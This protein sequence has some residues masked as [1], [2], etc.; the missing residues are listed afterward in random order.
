M[1]AALMHKLE[2]FLRRQRIALGD[3]VVAVSG[4]PDSVALLRALVTLKA[5]G[6]DSGRLTVAH[7]NH[8]LRGDESDEDE[9]FVR[10]LT[11]SLAS[12]GHTGLSLHCQRCEVRSQAAKEANNL[13]ATA[14]SLR[15]DWLGETARAARA[16]FVM[17]GHTADDQAETIL[18]HLLRGTGLKGLRGIAARRG[19]V[20]GVELVRPLLNVA[21][22]EV[23]AYLQ[24]VGQDYREDS[25]NA[26]CAF[27]R[28]RIR[29]ELIPY[30]ATNYNPEI[31]SVLTR[32]AEQA[33]ETYQD[34]EERA[35]GLLTSAELP[36]A[37]TC[38]VFSSQRLAAAGRFLQREM[39]RLAWEREGWP[40]GKMGFEDWDRL[41]Q[42][43]TGEI[44]ALDFPGGI[45]ARRR[46]HVVLIGPDS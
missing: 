15:Y 16:H 46:D 39:F 13:E 9:R 38:L 45:R 28:N 2:G 26:N 37:G 41:T 27:T 10:L 19:L 7:F 24:E 32:L 23:L 5:Q 17:T 44:V 22:A 25:S 21:R 31:V 18:H 42:V 33:A 30:L 20:P 14:R 3:V 4:G 34:L 6:A 29:H 40:M 8:Q 1:S 43:L 11:A 35:R 12:A 36:R